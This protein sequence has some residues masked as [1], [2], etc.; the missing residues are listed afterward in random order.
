V[1]LTF[2]RVSRGWAGRGE[3]LAGSIAGF[4]D[5]VTLGTHGSR[6]S[7]NPQIVLRVEFPDGIP[8]D[9]RSLHWRGRSYDHFD[10]IR[11]RRSPGLPPSLAPSAW[12]S[13]WGREL[14]EQRIYSLPL[15]A[16]VLFA[17]H[18]VMDIDAQSGIQPIV[19][20]VGDLHYWGSAAPAYTVRSIRGRP[21][22]EEL[23]SAQGDFVPARQFYLQTPTLDAEV[24]ALADSILGGLPTQYDKAQALAEWFQREFSYTLE[25]PGSPR[26]AT[27]EHFLLRRRAGHCEYFSTAMAILLRSQGIAAREVNGFLGGEWSQ[28]GDYL[29]VTQNQAHA[30]VEV[31]FPGFGWVPFDPTPTGSGE[32]VSERA[33]FWPGRFLFDAV[34]HRWNKWILDYSFQTQFGLLRRAQGFFSAGEEEE[35]NLPG[36]EGRGVPGPTLWWLAG[37]AL[38]AT[39]GLR[40]LLRTA[41]VPPST[42]L[43][44]KLREAGRRAGVP[45]EALHSPLSLLRHLESTR[46]PGAPP[47]GRVV[48]AYL[49]DRYS[50]TPVGKGGLSAMRRDLREA[51]AALR[52]RRFR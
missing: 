13:A 32:G 1:F 5:E 8:A 50:G 22:P 7:G 28:F 18:P 51:T 43:L 37:F 45:R 36:G 47:A 42:R 12:Y 49:R 34:Q 44:L 20:N 31:W 11:W 35:P 27:L 41:G 3:A 23:R 14:L 29:A 17:L 46:H 6:I 21:S 4:S 52:R 19:D 15:D 9:F 2:P 39:A 33:W 30:W 10:G 40:P 38:L 16:R 25:L 24:L 48:H 26:E